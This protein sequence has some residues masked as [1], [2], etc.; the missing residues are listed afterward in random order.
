MWE[1]Q[2]VYKKSHISYIKMSTIFLIFSVWITAIFYG[3]N[4]YLASKTAELTTQITALE[5][6]ISSVKSDPNLI[7]YWLVEAN[8]AIISKFNFMSQI[9]TFFNEIDRISASYKVNFKWF[10]YSNWV[11]NSEV[12][13]VSSDSNFAYQNVANFIKSY[14][15]E[16]EAVFTLPFVNS[17]DW[18][19]EIVFSVALKAKDS[20]KILDSVSAIDTTWVSVNLDLKKEE[21]AKKIREKNGN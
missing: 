14:R 3:T 6:N 1:E 12:V 20:F 4:Y 9:P 11:L 5:K 21:I 19:N 7:A 2:V 16:K 10:N 18:N 15:Q 8:K 13:W 17:F